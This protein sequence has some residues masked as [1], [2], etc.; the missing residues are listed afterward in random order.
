MSEILVKKSELKDGN[1]IFG[2]I[3]QVSNKKKYLGGK[4]RV[5]LEQKEYQKKMELRKPQVKKVFLN[6]LLSLQDPAKPIVPNQ[7]LAG[8]LD[9]IIPDY[10][11]L[12]KTPNAKFPISATHASTVLHIAREYFGTAFDT[13]QSGEFVEGVDFIEIETPREYWMTVSCLKRICMS[14]TNETGRLLRQYFEI[15]SR[16]YEDYMGESIQNAIKKETRD[17]TAFKLLSRPHYYESGTGPVHYDYVYEVN[18]VPY[19]HHGIAG[20]FNTRIQRHQTTAPY[21]LQKIERVEDVNPELME[22]FENDLYSSHRVAIPDAYMATRNV[23]LHDEKRYKDTKAFSRDEIKSIRE[24][25]V[26]KFGPVELKEGTSSNDGKFDSI[27]G[28]GSTQTEKDYVNS[29]DGK[30]EIVGNDLYETLWNETTSNRVVQNEITRHG[31]RRWSLALRIIEESR[32]SLEQDDITREQA[33]ALIRQM[34]TLSEAAA[35]YHKVH[36]G[37]SVI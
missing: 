2:F 14:M 26:E 34:T 28:S 37:F 21:I 15:V 8:F 7:L 16:G 5:N 1:A 29:F 10:E 32:S 12:H 11:Q 33:L 3:I 4:A 18:G 35:L 6:H 19:V 17:V 24:R 23:F 31:L 25:F 13:K 20:D 9:L 36:K 22:L 30:K 27:S